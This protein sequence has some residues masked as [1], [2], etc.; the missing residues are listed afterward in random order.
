M[1]AGEYPSNNID[2]GH[3]PCWHGDGAQTLVVIPFDRVRY[4]SGL[5]VI[6]DSA[7]AKWGHKT[8]STG[9]KTTEVGGRGRINMAQSLNL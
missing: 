2:L 8:W 1:A 7:L 4:G 3:F 9:R 5:V 6:C